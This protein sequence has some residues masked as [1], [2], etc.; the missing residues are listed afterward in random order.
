MAK[1]LRTV[2]IR[3]S[4]ST[5]TVLCA[6][7]GVFVYVMN[8]FF[9]INNGFGCKHTVLLL[10]MPVRDFSPRSLLLT[11]ATRFSFTLV[12]AQR[13][14]LLLASGLVD[15]RPCSSLSYD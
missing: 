12:V 11:R 8:I 1:V 5:S 15:L 6:Q 2:P 13:I 10:Q 3:S 7:H 4:V 9:Y 14:L